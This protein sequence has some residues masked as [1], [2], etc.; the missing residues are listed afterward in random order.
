MRKNKLK[1]IINLLFVIGICLISFPIIKNTI[2]IVKFQKT[3][4]VIKEELPVIKPNERI[5]L[6]TIE[7]Y[8]T[9][10]SENLGSAIGELDIPSQKIKTPIF[11][12]LNNQQ[13]LFGAGAMY[14]ERN[15]LKDNMVLLGH[16]LSMTELLLG[17]IQHL[18]VNDSINVTYLTNKLK[19]RVIKKKIVSETNLKV[20][21]STNVPQLTLITC[22]KP[23]LTDKRIIVTAELVGHEEHE[24]QKTLQNTKDNVTLNKKILRRSIVKHSFIPIF[25]MFVV[26]IIGSYVIWRYV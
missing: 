14:P 7:S 3:K 1:I 2:T 19:Y 20:L 5:I 11:A 8:L 23:E 18:E 4:I 15:V 6:P 21:E 9:V 22:D 10:S 12:G 17:N 26:L 13:M 25:I 16:H 24:K